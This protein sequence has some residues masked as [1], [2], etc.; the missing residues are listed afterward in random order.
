MFLR[1][2]FCDEGG[3]FV[4]AV[5]ILAK[6]RRHGKDEWRPRDCDALSE[7]MSAH[8]GLPLDVSSKRGGLAVIAKALNEGDVVRAQ[9]ATV[10]LGVPDPP[11]LSKGAPSRQEMNELAR[12]LRRSGLLK[13]DWDPDQH[14]RWPVGATDSQGGRFAPNGGDSA[15][16]QSSGAATDS[17]QPSTDAR[18]AEVPSYPQPHNSG[19]SSNSP[20]GP[21]SGNDGD[22]DKRDGSDADDHGVYASYGHY[23]GGARLAD[24]AIPLDG[25]GI[26][27][28]NPA[29]WANVTR[30]VNG[31]L[32]ARLRPNHHGGGANGGSRRLFGKNRL[33]RRD[34]QI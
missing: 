1:G 31:A 33:Q 16:G 11:S 8:F 14:P 29:N 2:V 25:L 19:A 15:T 34:Q 9:V 24:A 20:S 23:I 10:L 30:L 4:G 18:D 12:D 17:H 6:T 13:A 7:E 27:G 26:P 22:D 3:A 28:A 32:K 21:Q 5:P